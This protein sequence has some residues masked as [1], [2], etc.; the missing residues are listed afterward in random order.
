MWTK[1]TVR[2]RKMNDMAHGE[3]Q[4]EVPAQ[5]GEGLPMAGHE[6]SE[7]SLEVKQQQRPRKSDE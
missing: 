3:H 6:L 4:W 7:T 5:P 2:L 1:G